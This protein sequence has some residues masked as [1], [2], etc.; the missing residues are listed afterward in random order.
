MNLSEKETIILFNE[1]EPLAEIFTY[2]QRMKRELAQLAK[3]RPDE[4]RK[5]KTNSE[6]GETYSLPKKWVKIRAARILTDTQRR[7][8]QARARALHP[9]QIPAQQ[10]PQQRG[11]G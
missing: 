5:I 10:T 4:A 11:R 8:L 3:N 9:K 2:N 1:Q 6:G 7:D